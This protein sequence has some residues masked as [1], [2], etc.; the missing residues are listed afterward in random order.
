[1]SESKAALLQ[2]GLIVFIGLLVLSGLEYWVSVALSSLVLLALVAMMKAVLIMEYYMH[3]R[4]VGQ[5][6]E[7][8]SHR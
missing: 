4:L 2:R 5:S 1:M 3:L 7:E 6:E 8:G